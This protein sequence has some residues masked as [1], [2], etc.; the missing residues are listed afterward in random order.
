MND[1]QPITNDVSADNLVSVINPETMQPERVVKASVEP[2]MRD[3]KVVGYVC[4][5]EQQGG[6]LASMLD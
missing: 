6:D 4:D 1:Q 5:E 2:V 3:G